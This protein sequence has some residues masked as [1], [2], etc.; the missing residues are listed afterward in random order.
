MRIVILGDLH[1]SHYTDPSHIEARERLF[2]TFFQQVAHLQPDLVFAI[3]DTTNLGLKEELEGLKRI[4]Q[5][6]GLP[7]INVVGNHDCYAQPKSEIAPY[8]LGGREAVSTEAHYASFSSG[9]IHFIVLDTARDRDYTDYSGWVSE[10]QLQWLEAEIEQFNDNPEL[11]QLFV[12]GHH[13]IYNT[14]RLSADVMSYID[15]SIP[16]HSAFNKLQNK[17]GFY[18]CGHN[19]VNSIA[20]PDSANWYHVQSAAPLDCESFRLL[21]INQDKIEV[22]LVKFDLQSDELRKDFETVRHNIARGFEPREFIEVHG[23]PHEHNLTVRLNT[24]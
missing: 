5:N 15:N 2:S 22:E 1:Y 21:T 13:P 8:F 10:Q 24:W 9:E 14:T 4:L 16:V 6:S 18:I 17:P 23:E 19:H 20:G 11:K 7:I 12:L 3:G